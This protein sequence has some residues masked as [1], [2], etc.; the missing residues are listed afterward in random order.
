MGGGRRSGKRET[1]DVD[2]LP[3]GELAGI[4]LEEEL[5]VRGMKGTGVQSGGRRFLAPPRPSL[6]FLLRI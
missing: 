6:D 1:A 5:A 3:V 2:V 4:D